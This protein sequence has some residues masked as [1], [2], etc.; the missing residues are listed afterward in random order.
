MGLSAGFKQYLADEFRDAYAKPPDA[1]SG[2][3]T[4][5][6]AMVIL[7]AFKPDRESGLPTAHQ[8]ADKF[9]FM[10]WESPVGVL[11]FDDVH[12]TPRTKEKEWSERNKSTGACNPVTLEALL[13]KHELPSEWDDFVSDRIGRQRLNAYLSKELVKRMRLSRGMANI[14]RLYIFNADENP[15]EVAWPTSTDEHGAPC[16]PDIPLHEDSL[17]VKI[18]DDWSASLVGEGELMSVRA[19]LLLRNEKTPK[20]V[21]QTC[22]TDAVLISMLNSFPGLFVQLSHYD[23]KLSSLVYAL[24][25]VDTLSAAVQ[26]RLRISAQDFCIIALSKGSDFVTQS[27]GGIADWK[28]YVDG[29]SSHIKLT[30]PAVAN[31]TVSG[32]KRTR[33][34][35][36]RVDAM[37]RSLGTVNKRV[38][39]KYESANHLKRLAWNALYFAHAVSGDGAVAEQLDRLDRFGWVERSGIMQPDD[40]PAHVRSVPMIE[41]N[42]S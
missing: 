21:I 32:S 23:R 18:R 17:M 13:E 25:D 38:C 35:V 29:C 20:V 40:S 42:L 8:L 14:Q 24:I 39:C 19:A 11:C 2:D 36:E 30:S 37:L 6:D 10:L 12:N 34:D 41:M 22:D 28:K 7:H 5:V 15:L 3:V 16:L 4:I 33:V 27:V 1:V 26:S 31:V 9:Y